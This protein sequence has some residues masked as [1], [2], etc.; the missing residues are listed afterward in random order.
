MDAAEEVKKPIE[1][2]LGGA[3]LHIY[4]LPSGWIPLEGV[5][6]VKGLDEDGH[7]S[8]VFRT[9][10]GLNDEELLGVL[11][12]RTELCRQA[13]VDLYLDDEDDED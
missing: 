6:L 11:T 5:V 2:V 8:W 7:S 12:V 1:E 9:T 3:G 10:G 4:D 13:T